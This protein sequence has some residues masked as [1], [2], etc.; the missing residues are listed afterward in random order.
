MFLFSASCSPLKNSRYN[1]YLS[2]KS[3]IAE[4]DKTYSY[5]STVALTGT[6]K[7]YKRG[8]NLV[9]QTETENGSQVVKLK[10]LT[11][12]DPL[13]DALPIKY[14]E[15]IV[16]NSNNDIIQCGRTDAEGN[17]KALDATSDLLIP[18]TPANYTVRVLSR[19]KNT[20][21]NNITAELAVKKDKYT[22]E[23][24]Y[25]SATATSNGIDDPSVNLVAYARQTDSIA[26]EGGAFNILNSIYTSYKYLNDVNS[27]KSLN[28]S[29]L[30]DKLNIFW[31]IG[32]NP[33]QYVY[34]DQDPST[35]N[36][37]SFYDHNI[38]SLFI[39]G[40]RLGN[41]TFEQTNHFDDYVII[42]ELA[43]HIENVCGSLI[44][45]MQ[46]HS[47]IYRTDSRLTWA[48]A[49]SNYFAA[50]VMYKY[51]DD[52]DA[53]GVKPYSLNPE[54]RSKMKIAGLYDTNWTFLFASEGFS[55]SVQNI[56]SGS[57][58]MFDLKKA[59]N[60]PDTWQIGSYYGQSFDKVDPDRYPGEG[61]FREGAITRGLFKISNTC[62]NED[63]NPPTIPVDSGYCLPSG[64]AD[65]PIDF[66]FMWK[67]M[68]KITGIGQSSYTFKGSETFLDILRS[69]GATSTS[70][71]D[72]TFA[73]ILANEAL[74][75]S[76][77]YSGD[78]TKRNWIPYGT[79]LVSRAVST[80]CTI[81][82]LYFEPKS[83]DP[84][85]TRSSSDQRYSNHF[86]TLDLNSLAGL[87][88]IQVTFSY[89]KGN[90]VEFDLLLYT[91][92]YLFLD[93]YYCSNLAAN[94]TCLSTWQPARTTNSYVIR[95][96]RRSGSSIVT[97]T[98]R[99]LQ[100]L[101]PT[102]R[103]LLDIRAYTASKS[104]TPTTEYTYTITNPQETVTY[105]N[106]VLCP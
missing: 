30:N 27:D 34:P 12:G 40:G 14:A 42:H 73:P 61:H 85:L 81:N 89:V 24:Y 19:I 77:T 51:V 64:G 17:L 18:N 36:T 9:T 86:Y 33:Y 74:Q 25:I 67:S 79:K 105:P 28:L 13:K 95:S 38:K 102:R 32:F 3:E 1:E 43:H 93:D 88:Q 106:K 99:D 60:N 98:I 80:D 16:Y 75:L 94:G 31:K 56:G 66:K 58:F 29:C 39:T 22:N 55:D 71:F 92:D 21:T 7:F 23:L 47:I 54:F 5:S 50:Q 35:L 11:Q 96:D 49:W 97:K 103:Y 76:T 37:G 10:N 46:E 2:L 100:K 83:D 48:E 57:G 68:N 20:L 52:K 53:A 69:S 70:S 90:Y 65:P 4:C 62:E 78:S 87:D 63:P 72:S 91:D 15:V 59:G 101:D 6:A 45:P 104:I 84:A 44:S 8:V 41:I 26:V 82:P